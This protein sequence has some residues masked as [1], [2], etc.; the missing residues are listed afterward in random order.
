VDGDGRDE[1]ALARA[2]AGSTVRIYSDTDHDGLL[3]D[4]PTDSFN[5]FGGFMGGVRLAFGDTNDDGGDELILAQGPGGGTVWV[6]TDSDGDL[7]VSGEFL[8]ESFFAFGAA[9]A[10]G[11][12]VAAGDT[13][14]GGPGAEVF[15][16]R[17]AGGVSTVRMFTD[18]DADGMVGDTVMESFQAFNAGFVGGVRLAAGDTDQSGTTR[19]M[20]TAHGTGGNRVVIRDDDGDAGTL[21]SDNAAEDNFQ[22]FG[23]AYNSGLFVAF[24]EVENETYALEVVPVG[25]PDSPIMGVP[26]INV[27]TIL[28]PPGAGAIADLDVSLAV[29]HTAVGNL[30]FVLT[31]VPSGTAIALF[32]GIGGT[33]AGLF[34][35][36]DDEAD[37]DIGDADNPADE[38]ISGTYNPEGAAELSDFDGLD[39][40]GTWVLTMQD[41]TMF[42]TGALYGWS[43]HFRF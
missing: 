39:A 28:V 21:F 37:T 13:G 18:D 29:A 8:L 41:S 15:A 11:V 25:I 30:N 34:A 9:Y 24:A 5:A 20:I 23:A 2:S 36:L 32:T 12:Y 3:S 14:L 10:G 26:G 19:E 17:D 43:L 22:P 1:L 33:D 4:N 38:Y 27:A 31:H 40:S 6:A 7:A 35:R 16:G 42:N